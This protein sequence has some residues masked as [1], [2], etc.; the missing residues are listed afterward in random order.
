MVIQYAQALSIIFPELYTNLFHRNGTLAEYLVPEI[1]KSDFQNRLTAALTKGD[2]QN[3]AHPVQ[4]NAT[5]GAP[6]STPITN[7]SPTAASLPP[8]SSAAVAGPPSQNATRPPAPASQSQ[9]APL[10]KAQQKSPTKKAVPSKAPETTTPKSQPAADN[11][12]KPAPIS[13]PRSQNNKTSSSRA[14]SGSEPAPAPKVSVPRGPPTQ[15]RLQVRLFDG[16]SV[17]SSFTPTQKISTDVRPWLDA[18]MGEEPRPYNLKHILTPLPSRTLSVSE[19]SMTLQELGLGSTANLVMV[20]VASYTNAYAAAAGSLPVRGASAIYNVV[21]SVA[22]TASGYVGSLIGYGSNASPSNENNGSAG[23]SAPNN[24][25]SRQS[26]PNIRTLND[27]R[28]E[29]GGD[30]QFYNGNQVCGSESSFPPLTDFS[31]A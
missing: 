22:G 31:A 4:D 21:S 11:H 24:P 20:P 18:Q 19:E 12:K 29:R 9:K 16:S 15:Y 27:Q 1:P 6:E 8:P 10:N 26:G 13:Q 25:R 2:S 7:P 5:P 23:N 14:N 17:R 30:R 3:T 28:N